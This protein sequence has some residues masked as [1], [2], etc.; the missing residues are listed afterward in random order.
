M[1]E[2]TINKMDYSPGMQLKKIQYAQLMYKDI[3]CGFITE[4]GIFLKMRTS[5]FPCFINLHIFENKSF[6]E[7][8]ILFKKNWRAI[9]DRYDTIV[10]GL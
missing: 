3:E 9:Y 4:E 5:K 2:I 1:E 6:K 8:C 10:R 7:K